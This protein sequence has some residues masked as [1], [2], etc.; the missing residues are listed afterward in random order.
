MQVAIQKKKKM[1]RCG[2]PKY[3]LYL[4]YAINTYAAVRFPPTIGQNK[5]VVLLTNLVLGLCRLLP[6][7]MIGLR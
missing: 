2:S 6:P 4:L 3:L 1:K 7:P 5:S